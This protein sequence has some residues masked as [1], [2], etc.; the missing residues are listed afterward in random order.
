M[1]ACPNWCRRAFV[2][3][4][5]HAPIPC[6][7]SL[8]Q[9]TVSRSVHVIAMLD[10]EARLTVNGQP[11][12]RVGGGM[13]AKAAAQESLCIDDVMR[14]SS[15]VELIGLSAASLAVPVFVRLSG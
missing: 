8:S 15:A 9:L 4:C 5:R 7:Q 2:K 14:L 6:S 12:A 1:H 13:H 3:K 11:I 10:L